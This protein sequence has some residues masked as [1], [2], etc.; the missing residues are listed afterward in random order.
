MSRY[1]DVYNNMQTLL[2][3]LNKCKP[4][5]TERSLNIIAQALLD[6]NKSLAIMIDLELERRRQNDN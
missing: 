2:D 1:D 6:I 4:Q 3:Q 5:T